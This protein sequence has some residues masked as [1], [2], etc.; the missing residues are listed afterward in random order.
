MKDR[1]A[2]KTAEERE[3]K[4]RGKLATQTA[5]ERGQVIPNDVQAGHRDSWRERGQYTADEGQAGHRDSWREGGLIKSYKHP[6]M[7][8]NEDWHQR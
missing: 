1:L 4:I 7:W 6:T 2:A 3:V 5:E 8:K